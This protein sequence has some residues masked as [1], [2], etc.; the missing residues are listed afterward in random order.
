MLGMQ[1]PLGTWAMSTYEYSPRSSPEVLNTRSCTFTSKDSSVGIVTVYGLDDRSSIPCGSKKSLYFTASRQ[2]LRPTPS[3]L[4]YV[5]AALSL[6]VKS[7]ES[8]AN[9]PPPSR[10]E[11]NNVGATTQFSIMSWCLVCSAQE[12]LY[13]FTKPSLPHTSS[14]CGALIQ[15]SRYV[16]IMPSRF[17]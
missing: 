14:I 7:A 16:T 13:H 1:V 10:A 9:H 6:W 3:P 12:Q 2:A 8:N 11:V 5:P 17:V 15:Y 4:Q